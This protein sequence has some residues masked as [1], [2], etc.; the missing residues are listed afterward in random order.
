[1]R[2]AMVHALGLAFVLIGVVGLISRRRGS[3]LIP[4]ASFH[5]RPEAAYVVAIV[6]GVS[7]AVALTLALALGPANAVLHGH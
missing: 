3:S 1:M 4:E 6:F 2:H 5:E 7:W